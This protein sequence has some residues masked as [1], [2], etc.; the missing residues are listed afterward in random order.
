MFACNPVIPQMLHLKNH[1]QNY[2]GNRKNPRLDN[3]HM[4]RKPSFKAVDLVVNKS[5][6]E[7]R[8]FPQPFPTYSFIKDGTLRPS[9]F[10]GIP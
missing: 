2:C 8:M 7:D 10:P 9:E 5:E 3:S 1:Q 6:S 4:L